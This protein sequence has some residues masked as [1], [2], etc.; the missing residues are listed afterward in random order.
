MY[1]WQNLAL[2]SVACNDFNLTYYSSIILGSFSVMLF[3]KLC[4]HIGLT[5]IKGICNHLKAI[6]A[7][8]D[9]WQASETSH[10][11][12]SL[13]NFQH[14]Y[15]PELLVNVYSY[16]LLVKS[17]SWCHVCGRWLFS[18]LVTIR[19]QIIF[20]YYFRMQY[21]FLTYYAHKI[22]CASFCTKLAWLLY[23]K[24]FLN[25]YFITWWLHWSFCCNFSLM[26]GYQA[27]SFLLC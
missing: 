11:K 8:V 19:F 27:K 24:S 1:F 15:L 9:I 10:N 5:L 21:L 18:N 20:T 3:P 14:G 22:T 25:T 16:C 12:S 4:W 23:H 7:L 17:V 2:F 26:Y 13:G 6:R